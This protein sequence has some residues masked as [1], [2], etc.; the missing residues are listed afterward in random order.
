MSID[1]MK[2]YSFALKDNADDLALLED[3]STGAKTLLHPE[4]SGLDVNRRKNGFHVF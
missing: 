3:T 1:Q 2:G 4:A